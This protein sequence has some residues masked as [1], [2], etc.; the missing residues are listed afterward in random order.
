VLKKALPAVKKF[1]ELEGLAA[2]G[3]SAEIRSKKMNL[4]SRLEIVI[5]PPRQFNQCCQSGE[6]SDKLTHQA[7]PASNSFLHRHSA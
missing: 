7:L 2:H 3:K 6:K 4:Q 1:A 5:N